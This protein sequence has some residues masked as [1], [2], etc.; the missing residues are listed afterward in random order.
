M[1]PLGAIYRRKNQQN[2]GVLSIQGNKWKSIS[3]PAYIAHF[4]QGQAMA[5]NRAGSLW[6]TIWQLLIQQTQS[7]HMIRPA[8]SLVFPERSWKLTLT[9]NL[10]TDVY[11]NF[12]HRCPRHSWKDKWTILHQ[13]NGF[14]FSTQ[15]Q[16]S[17]QA[18]ERQRG[19]VKA[20]WKKLIWEGHQPCESAI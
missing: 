8:C 11:D 15:K 17:Y 5:Q 18:M 19:K 20:Q 10:H 2:T 3:L 1:K 13:G 9:Q 6:Q 4:P 7:Y 14:F 16:M 12:F